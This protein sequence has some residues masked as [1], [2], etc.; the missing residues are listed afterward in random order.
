MIL[1]SR[2]PAKLREFG[3]I[4]GEDE[5]EPLPEGIELPPEVGETFAANAL[6][7]ARAASVATGQAA[8]ADDSGLV[9]DELGGMPG[10]RSA[11]Y[12]GDGATDG[13][14]LEKLID[15]V[16]QSGGDGRARYVC[17]IALVEPDGSESIFEAT[18]EGKVIADARGGGGF[19]Y[20]PAFI[21]DE[22]GPEDHRTMAELE[23]GEKHA[24]SHRG[25]AARALAGAL[26]GSGS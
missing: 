10:V 4:L 24:I 12:A 18:C 22:T 3:E 13:Q 17:V 6:I 20:D 14:N 25:K 26:G 8:F 21:P 7:K 16:S 2:N 1:A 23:P 19:G 11:R 15:A 9:V 5:V